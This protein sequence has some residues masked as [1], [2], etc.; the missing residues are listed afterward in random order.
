MAGG[1]SYSLSLPG[2]LSCSLQAES[3]EVMCMGNLGRGLVGKPAYFY[4]IG[5][6]AKAS[7]ELGHQS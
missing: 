5:Q 2:S 4:W 6:G 3:G 7:L 1:N